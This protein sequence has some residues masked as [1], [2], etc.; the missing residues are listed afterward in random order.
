MNSRLVLFAA[1]SAFV[2]GGNSIAQPTLTQRAGVE[3]NEP[4]LYAQRSTILIADAGEELAESRRKLN[5]TNDRANAQVKKDAEAAAKDF[6]KAKESYTKWLKDH[7]KASS[8]EK[9]KALN[10]L[11]SAQDHALTA[12][13]KYIKELQNTADA[14]LA[15]AARAD[16]E[17][18]QAKGTSDEQ[19]ASKRA[20]DAKAALA[21]VNQA[22]T[23]ARRAKDKLSGS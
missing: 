3:T 19:A 18:G 8:D 17:M 13:E 4:R 22:I 20:A 6:E 2:A 7:P 11:K 15:V 23:D 1:M 9:T 14:R 12:Y 21:A 5:E 10:P 16:K